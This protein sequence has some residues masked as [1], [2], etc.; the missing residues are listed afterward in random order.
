VVAL[1]ITI[2][3]LALAVAAVAGSISQ[4]GYRYRSIGSRS[5]CVILNSI[6][7]VT[8]AAKRSRDLAGDLMLVHGMNIGLVAS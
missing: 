2:A 3:S 8:G 7:I 5:V 4:A 6:R 1:S